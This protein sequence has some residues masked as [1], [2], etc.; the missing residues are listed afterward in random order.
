MGQ[1]R[2][3]KSVKVVAILSFLSGCQLT[4]VDQLKEATSTA[5]KSVIEPVTSAVSQD[6]SELIEN[7]EEPSS[8]IDMLDGSLANK[9]LGSDFST[10][11]KNALKMDPIIIAESSE[12]DARV[13][14]IGYTEARKDFQVSS[15]LLAGI[16][17]ITDRT[18]GLAVSL[19]ASR[20]LYDGGLV[21]AQIDSA[22]YSAEAARLG[23]M[24]IVD[25]RAL[26]L[27]H[28][29]VELEK[30]E[31][32][33]KKISSRL[34]VLDPLI[35]QLDQ[36][37]KA[38]IGDL[39]KVAAA[40]R[41]VSL[42]RVTE[43]NISERLAKARL[44]FVNAF[45]ALD[46]ELNYDSDFVMRLLPKEIDDSLIQQ[47][48]LLMSQYA[49]YKGSL[50][51]VLL[52][53]AKGDFNIGFEARAMRPFAGSGHDSDE[54]VGLVARKTLFNGKMFESELKEAEAQVAKVAAQIRATFR[55]GVRT[56]ETAQQNIDS[57]DKAIVLARENASIT[58]EEIIY[59]KQQLVIGGSTLDSVL[60]AEAR[61]YDAESNEINFLAEKR[62]SQLIILSALGLLSRTLDL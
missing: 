29:W 31:T 11:I 2:G 19:S 34:A 10:A 25:E 42:I 61:L 56:I 51:R 48:P 52:I 36:V 4:G 55:E 32:L 12:V 62:K 17:D 6:S 15:T 22:R 43:T 30:Y 38:G 46:E 45:G 59:L 5:F 40:Q 39:S 24:A 35:E 44:D 9:N 13:A 3:F 18:K 16:E 28:L 21:D 14:A 49:N 50:A 57:M 23:Y 33:E 41:T 58:A 20:L 60:S 26:R 8:L 54:S 1:N 53:K 37:A 47:S 7:V 27:G